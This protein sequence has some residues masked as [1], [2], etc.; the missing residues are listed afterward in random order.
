MKNRICTLGLLAAALIIAPNSAFAGQNSSS[1]NQELNQSVYV[2][3]SR[4][5]ANVHGTQITNQSQQKSSACG[6][7]VGSQRQRSNQIMNQNV[8]IVGHRNR[9]NV[10]GTQRT[11]QEQV[12]YR[13][14]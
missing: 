14:C 11:N 12:A 2:N 8:G 6:Y 5:S 7:R 3:G 13:G 9:V 4:N 10:S 1:S